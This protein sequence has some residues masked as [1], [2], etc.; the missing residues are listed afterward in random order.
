MLT[1]LFHN[2][3]VVIYVKTL[4]LVYKIFSFNFLIVTNII[5]KMYQ[6]KMNR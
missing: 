6:Q 3:I 4:I 5:Y 1:L 2:E